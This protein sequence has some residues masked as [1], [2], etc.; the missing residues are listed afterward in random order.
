MTNIHILKI[1]KKNINREL[2]K[3]YLKK[4]SL[5]NQIKTLEEAKVNNKIRLH[6]LKNKQKKV[7]K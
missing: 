5:L 1:K 4:K 6:A 7:R 3:L 2:S